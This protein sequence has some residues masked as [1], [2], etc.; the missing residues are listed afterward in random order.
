M[1]SAEASYPS[2]TRQGP[3]NTSLIEK[4][5]T[6]GEKGL[7]IPPKNR[8]LLHVQLNEMMEVIDGQKNGHIEKS[9]PKDTCHG[10]KRRR[11]PMY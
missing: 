5:A 8:N 11:M 7:H 4:E 6:E 2:F 1:R 10:K 9:P 3:F